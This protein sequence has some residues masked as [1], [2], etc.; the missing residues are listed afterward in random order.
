MHTRGEHVLH[1]PKGKILQVPGRRGSETTRG[2][3][4]LPLKGQSRLASRFVAEI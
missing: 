2:W 4:Y 1:T 3:R